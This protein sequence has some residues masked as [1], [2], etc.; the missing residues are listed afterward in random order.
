MRVLEL[1]ADSTPRERGRLHGEMFAGEIRSLA[2]LRTYLTRTVGNFASDEQVLDLAARHMPVLEAFDRDLHQEL[3]GIAEG[4]GATPAQIVVLN[5]YTD[6]RDLDASGD[7][8]GTSQTDDGCT[9]VYARTSSGPVLAQTWDMHAT[10]MPYMLMLRTPCGGGEAW[11][12]SLTG[13]LGMTGISSTGVAVAINNMHSRDAKIGVVW[14]ALVR[15]AL[16]CDGAAAAR[17]IVL[18]GNVGSGHH[19]L[20]AD[21][22]SAYAIETSGHKRKVVYRSTDSDWFVHTNHCIDNEIGACSRVPDGSSTFDRLKSMVNSVEQR[23]I[24]DVRDAYDRLGS[25]DGYP[26]SVCT[27]MAT[28]EHPH[29]PATCAAVA[30]DISTGEV[31]AVAGFGHNVEPT[32]FS[33]AVKS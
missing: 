26:R 23:A 20:V 3:L 7:A 32:R 29:A 22:G 11:L 18:E 6:L 14:S 8:R 24:V 10:A 21:A 25:H 19:Y 33:V 9:V 2:E 5:H 30:Y 27:N 13:C 28:A 12:L 15:K 17:D 1:P 4:S 31:L 16:S